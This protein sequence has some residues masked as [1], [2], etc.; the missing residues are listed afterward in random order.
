MKNDI[1]A[2]LIKN[3]KLRHFKDKGDTFKKLGYGIINSIYIILCAV[4]IVGLAVPL[5]KR[6]AT[7]SAFFRYDTAAVRTLKRF[8]STPLAIKV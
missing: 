5:G 8:N 4:S 1:R 6:W 7:G 2:T 3:P